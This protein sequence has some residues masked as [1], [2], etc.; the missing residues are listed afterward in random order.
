MGP[1]RQCG[2]HPF[3]PTKNK[4]INNNIMDTKNLLDLILNE[5]FEE[6]LDYVQEY[7]PDSEVKDTFLLSVARIKLLINENHKG[8][9]RFEDF[10]IER[11]K[12]LKS[13]LDNV[14][15]LEPNLIDKNKVKKIENEFKIITKRVNNIGS[16]M[17]SSCY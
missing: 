7:S 17:I 8:T 3:L 6:A 15:T 12:I 4:K 11:N 13:M 2:R 1:D 10:Q 5:S 16:I 9:I 14:K